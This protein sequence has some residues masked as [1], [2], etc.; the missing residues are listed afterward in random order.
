VTYNYLLL[1]F[2][3]WNYFQLQ[4]NYISIL[5]IRHGLHVHPGSKS[6]NTNSTSGIHAQI[7]K[8]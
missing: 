4:H 8:E 2:A 3:H 6:S 1:T 5:H 7:K